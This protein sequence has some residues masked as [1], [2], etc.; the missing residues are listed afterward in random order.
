[1]KKLI[2]L[3]ML[4]FLVGCNNHKHEYDI[5]LIEAT[6]LE[7]GYTKYSCDCGYKYRDDYT[8]PLGHSYGDWEDIEEPDC[9]KY[10]KRQKSCSLCGNIISENISKLECEFSLHILKE[11]TLDSEGV[12]ANVCSHGLVDYELVLPAF[13]SGKYV[14]NVIKSPVGY[15]LGERTHK[16]DIN[17]IDY[18]FHE[19]F[20]GIK[21]FTFEYEYVG[22]DVILT[23]RGTF[24]GGVLVIPE[25]VTKIR[26]DAF[27]EANITKVVFPSTLKEIGYS[28]F[29]YNKIES[30]EIHENI[31]FIA[32]D[33]FIGN[34]LLKE[35]NVDV[36]NPVYY[37]ESNSIIIKNSKELLVGTNVIPNDIKIIGQYAF[38]D[39]DIEIVTIPLGVE[40]IRHNAFNN[41]SKLIKVYIPETVECL[42]D[43]S[44]PFN[45]FAGSSNLY[46]IVV[47]S[48]NKIFKSVNNSIIE[49][50]SNKLITASNNTVIEDGITVIGYSAFEGLNIEYVDI[51]DSVVEIEWEAFNNCKNLK[52]VKLSQNITTIP[53]R[54]FYNCEALEIINL[55]NIRYIDSRAFYNCKFKT[56]HLPNILEIDE[57]AFS[58]CKE[59]KSVLLSDSIIN[60]SDYVFYRCESL[61]YINLNNIEYI[62]DYAFY[63][64]N[65]KELN[66]SKVIEIGE[67]AYY[68]CKVETL[69]LPKSLTTIASSAFLYCDYLEDV[70]L[71]E[72]NEYYKLVDNTLVEIETGNILIEINEE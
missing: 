72:D 10:G 60:I 48:D 30:L 69:Y 37:S 56:L 52:E 23:K 14:T 15:S 66:L 3:L 5:E 43:L 20:E 67:F 1:M 18:V 41:C 26:Q 64:C 47:A 28:A 46:E 33:A 59:L 32:H 57:A 27:N 35:I 2:L 22:L 53:T 12:L 34:K 38:Y 4:L 45:V 65:I 58:M 71:D 70:I 29:G 7:G 25:G 11:P 63:K 8:K 19:E 24:S 21:D 17:G 31:T 55:E 40:V 54:A 36:D 61:D 51:P 16:I 44:Y 9:N 42:G 13:S 68:N 39:S 50:I 49:I 6:C 62:G